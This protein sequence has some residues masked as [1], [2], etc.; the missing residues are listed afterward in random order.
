MERKSQRDPND[1]LVRSRLKRKQK[2]NSTPPPP[3]S[4]QWSTGRSADK[5]EKMPEKGEKEK[6]LSS[7]KDHEVRREPCEYFA[8]HILSFGGKQSCRYGLDCKK[9]HNFADFLPVLKAIYKKWKPSLPE[10]RSEVIQ[11][12]SAAS[13]IIYNLKERP[14]DKEHAEFLNE[15]S[16]VLKIMEKQGYRKEDG[17]GKKGRQGIFHHESSFYNTNYY[18]QVYAIRL[19][20]RTLIS[21]LQQDL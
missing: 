3:D 14:V 19:Y 4:L 10:G 15:K 6:L 13:S 9:T 17:L 2:R 18:I 12:S 20:R 5:A 16:P 21:I 1:N 7:T 8:K 11:E